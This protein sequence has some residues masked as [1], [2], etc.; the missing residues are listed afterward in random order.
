MVAH[1]VVRSTQSAFVLGRNILEAVV[2][3]IHENSSEEN[4]WSIFKIYF[5]KAYDNV[6]WSFLRE[7]MRTRGFP[8]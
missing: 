8:P 6:K 7:A 4:G 2:V 5:G 3:L 1:I